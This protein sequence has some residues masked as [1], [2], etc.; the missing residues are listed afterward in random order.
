[1]RMGQ[2]S[3]E[4][5]EHIAIVGMGALGLMFGQRIR[6]RLGDD[7]LCFL[8]DK[9]RKKRHCQD[10]YQI[11]GKAVFFRTAIPEELDCPVDL[12]IVATKYSGLY[13]ARDLIGPVVGQDTT[14]VSLLNGI[15]SEEILAEVF[16]REQILD[17]VAI[18]MDAVR[19]GTYLT[20]QH[21]G[22]WQIGS[23]MKQQE[24]RLTA[25]AGFLDQ[26][27]I[28]YEVCADIK[29][30]MWNKFMINVGINQTC[31]VYETNYGGATDPAGA[32]YKDMEKAMHEV[33]TVA[34]AEGIDLTEEDFRN[35][36]KILRGLNPEGIPSMRQ[37]AL[38]GRP[39]EV[40]LFAGAMLKLAKRH[41]IEVPVNRRFYSRIKEM[42]RSAI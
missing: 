32:A 25:L 22:R 6:D 20:Y 15:S 42:E 36:M 4:K 14:I 19:D 17:C 41:S 7:K 39:S 3:I 34:K 26:A 2:E 30:A 21:I 10:E 28:A 38:A 13:E 5:I 33:I 23:I 24:R 29:R 18:G 31:M 40:E 27:G 37:D 11:N 9:D 35:D 16:P 1:M 12:V 8:M